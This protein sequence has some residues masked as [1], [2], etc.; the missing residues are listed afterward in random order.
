MTNIERITKNEERLDRI[1]A[2]NAL[3]DVAL[4]QYAATMEDARKL[5]AY[6]SGPQ[7]LKDYEDDEAGKLPKELKRGVLSEDGA[8]DAL[9]ERREL[10]AQMLALAAKV[11]KNG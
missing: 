7:W 3:L 2:A 10:L 9:T 4:E 6:Y 8:Y 1:L 11:L 5:D